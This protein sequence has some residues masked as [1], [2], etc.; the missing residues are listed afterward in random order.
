[1]APYDDFFADDSNGDDGTNVKT[2]G[3]QLIAG[4][5]TFADDVSFGGYYLQTR[6]GLFPYTSVLGSKYELSY[7][8]SH[9]ADVMPTQ[10]QWKGGLQ[11][12][13]GTTTFKN[14]IFNFEES[15]HSTANPNP[16]TFLS[17]S[18][19]GADFSVDIKKGGQDVA[20]AN[21]V[22]DIAS[23]QTITGA[24]TFSGNVTC[25]GGLNVRDA[26]NDELITF[27]SEP[28]STNF[29]NHPTTGL[30][31]DLNV[32]TMTS[33]NNL[34]LST[35][36]DGTENGRVLIHQGNVYFASP[37]TWVIFDNAQ[38]VQYNN[39]DVV[40]NNSGQVTF[41]NGAGIRMT[42]LP[43]SASPGGVALATGTLYKDSN[44]FLKVV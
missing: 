42:T 20:L 35:K 12:D 21:A 44:G 30:S 33:S 13:N 3:T 39:H 5:K 29:A 1:M 8:D 34:V 11:F 7:N 4:M 22:C 41:Q 36:K 9:I 25:K 10:A 27:T 23:T 16:A 31:T 6:I 26:N 15:F 18:S 2:T 40:F 24:K 43:T 14:L 17:V 32:T 19:T 28:D 38:T 37:T